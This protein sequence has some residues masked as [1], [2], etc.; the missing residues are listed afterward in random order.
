M[1]R[2]NWLCGWILMTW[3]GSVIGQFDLTFEPQWRM[4]C[5]K[6]L[7]QTLIGYAPRGNTSAG[8]YKKNDRIK[9]IE[10]CVQLCCTHPTCNVVF[11]YDDDCFQVSEKNYLLVLIYDLMVK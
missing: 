5:P 2:Q 1:E 3:F 4:M 6:L 8:S 7:P 11:M 10:E 9:D